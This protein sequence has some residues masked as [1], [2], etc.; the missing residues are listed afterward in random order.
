MVYS[1]T[2]LDGHL[3]LPSNVFPSSLVD[4][5]R[6]S[7]RFTSQSRIP[8]SRLHGT[9]IY[10]LSALGPCCCAQAFSSCGERGP[11]FVAVRGLL[12]AVTSPRV[13][14]RL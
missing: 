13:E 3:A 7:T 10:L 11:L 1:S 6:I 14:H 9:F 5:M 8:G 2:P 4:T 12:I